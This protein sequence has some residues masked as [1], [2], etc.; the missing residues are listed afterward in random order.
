MSLPS[1]PMAIHLSRQ[2][3]QTPSSS[4]Q[5]WHSV[6]LLL[7]PRFSR[8][9]WS[10]SLLFSWFFSQIPHSFFLLEVLCDFSC[11]LKLFFELND[12]LQSWQKNVFSCTLSCFMSWCLALMC[13]CSNPAFVHMYS[14]TSHLNVYSDSTFYSS[15]SFSSDISFAVILPK[16]KPVLVSAHAQNFVSWSSAEKKTWLGIANCSATKTIIGG[17]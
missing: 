12:L 7:L 15:L 11:F 6:S 3:L 10:R 9:C 5:V 17:D 2:P 13:F 8:T 16:Q 14:H 4:I 1:L